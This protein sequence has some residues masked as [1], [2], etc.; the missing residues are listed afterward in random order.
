MNCRLYCHPLAQPWAL[1]LASGASIE[2]ALRPPD[3]PRPYLWAAP[4]QIELHSA[5]PRLSGVWVAASELQ[6][7]A[8]DGSMLKRACGALG[9]ATVLD[10][11]AGWGVDALLLAATG[12]RVVAFEREPSLHLLSRDLARRSGITGVEFV[13]GDGRRALAA[14]K[15]F[16][17]VYLDPMFSFN[18]KT[19]LPGK[20]MQV[21]RALPN[22]MTELTAQDLLGWIEA[23]RAS[24]R[25]RV[26]LKR[27]LKDPAVGSPHWQIKGRSVRYDVY[28]GTVR[29]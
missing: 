8:A 19:A 14:A 11:M 24:A 26:V 23:A 29:P 22:T 5:D 15:P 9:D 25:R 18:A 13:C 27:R 4:E 2:L 10:P 3:A 20:R 16:D 17:L 12:A 1:T 6:R 21:T 7:R 28:R